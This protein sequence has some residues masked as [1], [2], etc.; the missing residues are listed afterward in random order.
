MRILMG[1]RVNIF[2]LFEQS[3]FMMEGIAVELFD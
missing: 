1:K 3:V 2:Y